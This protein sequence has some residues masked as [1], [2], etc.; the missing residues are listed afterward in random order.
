MS[1]KREYEV[2]THTVTEKVCVKETMHCDVCG[3]EM[4]K[5]KRH[6]ELTTGHHDWGN[7]S[8]E[9]IEDFDICSE[10]CL[11]KKFD[12]YVKESGASDYNTMYFKVEKTY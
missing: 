6:W 10:E 5:N 3:N 9:S 12:E 7:D 2:K 8:V 1:I 4:N 11:R